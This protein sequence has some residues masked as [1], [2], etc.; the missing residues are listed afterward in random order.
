MDAGIVIAMIAQLIL[1]AI[2]LT[3]LRGGLEVAEMQTLLINV[4]LLVFLFRNFCEGCQKKGQAQVNKSA[5]AV[6][7]KAESKQA[8]APKT[9]AAA[10]SG[11]PQVED[12]VKSAKSNKRGKA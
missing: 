7:G 1:T 6:S 8:S 10:V 3:E 11:K 12:L 9:D 4:A 2:D 5:V